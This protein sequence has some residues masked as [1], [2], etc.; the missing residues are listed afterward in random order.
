[1]LPDNSEHPIAFASRTLTSSE[2]NY[3]LVEREAL[4]IV[5][6]VKKFHQYLYGRAFILVTDH[7]PLLA[8][9][10]Q[11]RASPMM[12]RSSLCLHL[13]PY[14]PGGQHCNADALSR[15]PLPETNSIPL[16]TVPACLN[17]GQI[18]AL[19]LTSEAV[20]RATCRDPGLSKVLSY[21]KRGWIPET[22][23]P[24]Y[25]RRFELTIEGD[26]LLWGIRVIIPRCLQE[27]VL[28]ELHRDHP[29]IT[30]M[31]AFAR[32]H[33]W[34]PGL[35]RSLE[36]LANTCHACQA[37]KQSPPAA[38]LHPWIWP[39]K[40]WQRVHVHGLRRAFQGQDVLS[41]SG[42]SLQMARDL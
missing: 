38:P 21:T 7:K 24:F 42:C 22:L 37:V 41:G 19:P 40:P 39:A 3:A 32:S 8:N 1:M 10:D 16:S 5:F 4:A 34:W 14:K 33:V 28:Q 26:C 13:P 35:D 12:G 23:K 27:D 11:R 2:N 6:P 31:K 18:Q 17:V 29:G 9:W 15:L 36:Q 20:Q 25:H 30:R